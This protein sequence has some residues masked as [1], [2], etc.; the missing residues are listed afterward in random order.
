MEYIMEP[1]TDLIPIGE[2]I[3]KIRKEHNEGQ[4][5]LA[6]AINVS[7]DSISKYER[8]VMRMTFDNMVLISN[9]YKVSLDYLIK[10]EGGSDLLDTLNTYIK[11]DYQRI[12]DT[13]PK[14]TSRPTPV[15]SINRSYFEYLVQ[16]ANANSDE[17][18]PA[19]LREQWKQIETEKFKNHIGKDNYGDMIS[20]IPIDKQTIGENPD[21]HIAVSNSKL[22]EFLTTE[23]K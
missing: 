5:E 7:K 6:E 18:I 21:L 9:H 2:R 10:G 11:L 17:N 23:Q 1:I 3:R 22:K 8:G 20:I 15:L 12:N 16:I 13:T 19:E 4:K 14:N